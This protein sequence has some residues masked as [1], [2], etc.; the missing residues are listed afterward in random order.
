MIQLYININFLAMHI[1]QL[2]AFLVAD[3]IWIQN[4]QLMAID[5]IPIWAITPVKLEYAFLFVYV[6]S[7]SI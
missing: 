5:K 2:L 6:I 7:V 1:C 4:A 3:L